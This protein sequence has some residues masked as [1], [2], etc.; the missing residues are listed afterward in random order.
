MNTLPRALSAAALLLGTMPLFAHGGQYRGPGEVIPPTPTMN[1]GN[2]NRGSS[3]SVGGNSSGSSSSGTNSNR[4]ATGANA[5][6]TPLAGSGNTGPAGASL[7]DDL[8]RWEFWWEFGKDPYLRLRELVGTQRGVSPDDQLWNARLGQLAREVAR[9]NPQDRSRISAALA[10]ILRRNQD[11]DTLSAAMVAL[12]K[13]GENGID[14]TVPGL[15]RGFLAS[16]D[17]E[18]RE[19]AALAIGI[20]GSLAPEALDTLLALATNDAV[21]RQ[22]SG[23]SEVN[24]RTRAFAI[25]GLGLLLARSRKAEVSLRIVQ[26]AAAQLPELPNSGRELSVAWIEALGTFPRDW[27]GKAAEVL[28]RRIVDVLAT[29]YEREQGPGMQ[30]VQA[31]IPTALARLVVDDAVLRQSWRDKFALALQQSL[32]RERTLG[33]GSKLNPHIAQSCALALGDLCE[34]WQD[35]DS[36]DASTC[37]LL[38]QTVQQ[39]RDHQT[40]SFALLALA[41]IGGKQALSSLVQLFSRTEHQ[42]ERPWVAMAIGVFAARHGRDQPQMPA[43][44]QLVREEL[45]KVRNP[46]AVSGLAV[47]LGIS[48]DENAVPILRELLRQHQQRDDVAGYLCLALGMLDCQPARDDLQQVLRASGRRPLAMLQSARGLGLLGDP[49]VVPDLCRELERPDKSLARLA[50]VAA[51]LGQI[52]DRRSLE[53]LLIQAQNA[54]LTPLARAFAV[55]ALGSI[56]DK[57]LL[58]W[59]AIYATSTNYRAATSTLTDGQ[60]GILDIL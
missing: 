31:H 53:P 50:A 56:C 24:D 1:S 36:G 54:D 9:P 47:A 38:L 34:P 10:N 20:H 17:Q 52:G 8:T 16:N 41:R 7:D 58:P 35:A 49:G 37:R 11:R 19:T 12:A 21:G 39:H 27:Q 25:Y 15:C 13:I 3:G 30:L 26:T 2:T 55:V 6:A 57:D 45:V 42:F 48:R 33:S 43:A 40:R 59:N 23:H 60:S 29:Q 4:P 5:G 46:Y 14:F 51:A 18:L 32:Q 44:L 22:L 28:R